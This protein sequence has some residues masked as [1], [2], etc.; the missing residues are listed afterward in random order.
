[1]KKLLYVVAAFAIGFSVTRCGG[2][3]S[4]SSGGSTS[5]F[6]LSGTLDL[7]N[8]FVGISRMEP[9]QIQTIES[10]I[11]PFAATQCSDGYFYQVYC[12]AFSEPP[13]SATGT[14]S[15]SGSTGGFTVSGLPKNTGIGCFVRRNTTSTG[16]FSTLGTLEIPATTMEGSTTTLVGSGD[17]KM[18]VSV[19]STGTISAVVAND[20]PTQPSNTSSAGTT[21]INASDFSGIY[22]ISCASTT[23]TEYSTAICKCQMGD[24]SISYGSKDACIADNGSLINSSATSQYVEL[25]LYAGLVS[26]DFTIT[27]GGGT[28]RTI[29]AG[30][31]IY[32]IGVWAASNSSTSLRTAGEGF[33]TTGPGASI[34]FSGAIRDPKVAVAWTNSG[35]ISSADTS[36]VTVN[37]TGH[38]AQV[39]AAIA[40]GTVAH[41]KTYAQWLYTQSSGFTCSWGGGDPSNDANCMAEFLNK[42]R[43]GYE[44][45]TNLVMPKVMMERNCGGSGCDN[46][47]ANARVFVE[48]VDFDYNNS[49]WSGSQNAVTV[50]SGSFGPRPSARHAF[51]QFEP[52]PGGG[53]GFTQHEF[54]RRTYPCSTGGS[55]I[56]S[57]LCDQTHN[58]L[59][60][61]TNQEMAIRFVP[62]TTTGTWKLLFEQR[63]ALMRAVIGKSNNDKIDDTDA[64]HGTTVRNLCLNKVGSEDGRFFM[65]A[66]KQ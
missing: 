58:W 31:S 22:Q 57:T 44:N 34:N 16:T 63:S 45:G 6:A 21:T 64:T 18:N 36:G 4:S 33:P 2:A 29:T 10:S 66:V 56:T 14:V 42:I 23:S 9:S 7:S 39:T 20:S 17:I 1:M 11:L 46:V 38:S 30:T 28:P 61:Q 49:S 48:G 12:V 19:D 25:S 40:G 59:E 52:A 41:W 5:T 54:N 65:N 8:T 51:E 32:G 27:D 13:V 43:R 26:A 47:L 62:T 50:R 24:W 60:C 3:S 55:E 53:G 37:L 35:S 15:C